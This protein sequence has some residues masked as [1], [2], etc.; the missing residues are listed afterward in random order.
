VYA[1]RSIRV[2][3]PDDTL[4][5]IDLLIKIGRYNSRDE[6]IAKALNDLLNREFVKINYGRYLARS[7]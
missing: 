1:L 7:Y 2:S 4:R 3:I 6:V 5:D